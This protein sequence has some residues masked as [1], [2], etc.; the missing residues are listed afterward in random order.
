MALPRGA[1]LKDRC[2]QWLLDCIMN[3]S[4]VTRSPF[5]Q[6][7]SSQGQKP[8][9]G[10]TSGTVL[11]RALAPSRG[12]GP[13]AC[14]LAEVVPRL[15]SPWAGTLTSTTRLSTGQAGPG[16]AGALELDSGLRRTRQ[17][18][19]PGLSH[20]PPARCASARSPASARLL[21]TPVA[22][23]PGAPGE[24][25]KKE[26]TERALCGDPDEGPTTSWLTPGFPPA[27]AQGPRKVS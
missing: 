13:L 26:A 27:K 20:G 25:W 14:S 7:S 10:V 15:C 2:R 9:S 8:G 18:A 23:R 11:R 19:Q 4:P 6:V 16:G 17:R 24:G 3:V 21:L 1:G 5:R 22:Q 12:P